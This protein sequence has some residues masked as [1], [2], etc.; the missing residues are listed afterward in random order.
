V[1]VLSVVVTVVV[2][3]VGVVVVVVVVVV[4]D[5]ASLPVLVSCSFSLF[6]FES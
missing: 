2:V 3:V 4:V 6:S 1:G 5:R